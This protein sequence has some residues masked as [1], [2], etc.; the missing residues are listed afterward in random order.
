MT[1]QLHNGDLPDNLKLSGSL[2]IDT[3]TTG[4]H[5]G[6]DRLCLIQI[7]TEN[8]EVHMVHFPDGNYNAPNL[9]SLLKDSN[10]LKIFHY[11]RFDMAIIYKYLDVMLKNVYCTKIAS[12]IARTY[13][14][15][16]GLK[17]ICKELLNV[18]ISKQQQS[19]YWGNNKLSKDQLQYAANDVIYL[20]NL[21]HS[22]DEILKREHRKALFDECLNSIELIVK[23]DLKGWNGSEI[24]AH[25]T[26]Q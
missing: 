6:R 16:H 4:L 24:F 22:L 2:A 9:K 25:R 20:H 11:A 1:I 7:A 14:D 13:T 19:S 15:N 3:E 10:I 12:K 21:K 8:K 23:L 17:D 18:Q 5:L 26:I